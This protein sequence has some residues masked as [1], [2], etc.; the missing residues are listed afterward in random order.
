MGAYDMGVVGVDN[1]S[2]EG[3]LKELRGM[4][5]EVLIQGILVRDQDYE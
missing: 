3:L 5:H 2:L 4:L 1:R